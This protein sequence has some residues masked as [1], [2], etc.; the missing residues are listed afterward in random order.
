MGDGSTRARRASGGRGSNIASVGRSDWI[1]PNGFTGVPGNCASR[2]SIWLPQWGCTRRTPWSGTRPVFGTNPLAAALPLEGQS[3]IVLDFSTSA[4]ASGKIRVVRDQ[5]GEVPEGWILDRDGRPSGRP[6]DY[7]DGVMLLPAAGHKGYALSLLVEVLGGLLTG[8]GAPILPDRR[9]KVGN[10]VLFIVLNVEA[11]R[12]FGD[13]AA[14]IRALTKT[15]KATPPAAG[16][17]E[18][19]LPG[20]P[21]WQTRMR[22]LDE[23]ISVPE[24]TWQAIV[25][26]ARSV[27]IVP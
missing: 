12:P 9:Y 18:V 25:D 24:A 4:V 19:F 2:F 15:I 8:A 20:E 7:Y 21:E 22:R 5:G 11:F 14:D 1:S 16:M 23:G 6:Q 10:G 17:D 26:A 13:F 3:P 27:G